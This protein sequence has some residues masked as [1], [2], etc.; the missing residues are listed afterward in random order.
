[1]RMGAKV[2]DASLKC[3]TYFLNCVEKYIMGMNSSVNGKLSIYVY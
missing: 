1:M 3:M 2:N